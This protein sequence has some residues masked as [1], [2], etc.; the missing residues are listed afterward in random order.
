MLNTLLKYLIDYKLFRKN[1]FENTKNAND[2]DES[3]NH[4]FDRFTNG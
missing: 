1:E 3:L 4:L 2:E